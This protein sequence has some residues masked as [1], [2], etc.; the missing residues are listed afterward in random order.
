MDKKNVLVIMTDQQ[1]KDSLGCYGNDKTS[2]PNLDR[3]ANIGVKFNNCFC[4]N[5]ICMPN[6]LSIFTGMYPRNHGMWTNGL[7][8]SHEVRTIANE[9]QDRGYQTASFGKLHFTPCGGDAGNLESTKYWERK[10]DSFDFNGPYWGFEH[11]E[12]TIGHTSPVAHYGRWFRQ[13]GGTEDMLKVKKDCEDHDSGVRDM[14]AKLHD[15]SFVGDRTVNF[16][17]NMRD[18]TKPFFALASF[19]DPHHPF[20]PPREISQKYSYDN[21]IEPIGG[22]EDLKTRPAHYMEH[23]KGGWHRKGH[24]KEGHPNGITIEQRNARIAHTYAMVD[25]ID[26]NVGKI[27]EALESEG[28]LK[29][30]IVIFTSD[31]GELLGDH[32]LWKKGPFFYNGLVNI[33]LIIAGADIKPNISDN[34]VSSID[35]YPTIFELLGFDS[36]EYVN[37]ISQKPH[38]YDKAQVPRDKC[39]IEYRNGYGKNDCSSK[40]LVTKDYKYVRYQDGECELTDLKNDP[41]EK[42]NIAK[43]KSAQPIIEEMNQILLDEILKTEAKY[44]EQISLA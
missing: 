37:G 3:L 6:R 28:L 24:V 8:L 22:I 42:V 12:L 16:I 25:L 5:P 32:G 14:P 10:G 26:Q 43:D 1:R 34:L 19:P 41:Y 36:P 39:L 29:D 27:I 44:P 18:K 9:L 11:V 2:T 31:H 20:N 38:L 23:F 4:T 33:P 40:V 35:I 17:K 21:I 15:S 7:L 30:T 13:N